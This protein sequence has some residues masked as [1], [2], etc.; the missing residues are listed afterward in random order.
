MKKLNFFV[1]AASLSLVAC[2]PKSQTIEVS[3]S[4]D[5][6]RNGEL[7]SAQVDLSTPHVL[8]DAQG[9]E[10]A[11]QV[12]DN[13]IFFLASVPASASSTYTW[14]EGTPADVEPLTAAF[15]LG[16]RRKDDFCWENDKAAYRM[17]GPALL[18]ENPSSGVDLWLKHSSQLTADAMY[19]Q[20]EGGRPYHVDYGLGIDSYKV[21]HAAGC[22]GL[23]IVYDNQIW[24]GG[25]Y[26]KYEVLQQGPLQ[27]IFRLSY[28]SVQVGQCVLTEDITITVNA[29]ADMNKAEVVLHGEDLGD[30]Q[31]G[32]AIF[33]HDSIQNLECYP[34]AGTVTY[35]ESANSDKGIYKIH[36]QQGIDASTLDFGRNYCAVYVPGAENFDQLANTQTAT[37]SYKLGDTLTYYFGGAWSKRDYATDDEWKAAINADAQ[38][39]DNPLSVTVK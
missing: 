5:F 10:V 30:I 19:K 12:V 16:D 33:L 6:A 21:G 20:E 1:L 22:G 31:L 32:G 38:C 28:D 35:C 25:P 3:N 17:Y 4:L 18:P 26:A 2:A 27:S 37:R 7:V 9:Q 13:Q 23:A 8:K 39:I 29:G 15:F 24:P 36:E 34:K 14:Q 11:Y